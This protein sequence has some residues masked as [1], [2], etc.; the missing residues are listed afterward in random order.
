MSEWAKDADF[1]FVADIAC[2]YKVTGAGQAEGGCRLSWRAW[3]A[4][5]RRAAT[6][7]LRTQEAIQVLHAH[8]EPRP[9]QGVL[10]MRNSVCYLS[11]RTGRAQAGAAGPDAAADGAYAECESDGGR[12]MVPLPMAAGSIRQIRVGPDAAADGAGP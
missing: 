6:V 5:A 7:N 10:E 4:P 9:A 1:M 3:P 8:G 12:I 2:A 11:S